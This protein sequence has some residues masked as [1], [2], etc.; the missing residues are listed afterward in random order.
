MVTEAATQQKKKN[1]PEAHENCPYQQQSESL[2][3][4]T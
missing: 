1:E 2:H 4:N 3:H